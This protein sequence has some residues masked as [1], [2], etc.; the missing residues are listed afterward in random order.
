MAKL[1]QVMERPDFAAEP[2]STQRCKVRSSTKCLGQTRR[3][4]RVASASEMVL[5]GLRWGSPR[6]AARR[7]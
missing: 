1:A 3:M 4:M 2:F 6:A 5:E 7:V